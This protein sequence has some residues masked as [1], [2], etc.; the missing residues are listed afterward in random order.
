MAAQPSPARLCDL[1]GDDPGLPDGRT[2]GRAI[3]KVAGDLEA[4]LNTKDKVAV[5]VQHGLLEDPNTKDIVKDLK[6][7]V[8]QSPSL[9]GVL[10]RQLATFSPGGSNVAEKLRSKYDKYLV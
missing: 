1:D 4:L 2:A 9:F 6:T 3:A 5:L 8:K 10:V 7:R